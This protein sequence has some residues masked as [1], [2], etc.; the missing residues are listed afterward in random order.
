MLI[1][2]DVF[3]SFGI[4][5]PPI[6]ILFNDVITQHFNIGR[7]PTSAPNYRDLFFALNIHEIK[8]PAKENWLALWQDKISNYYADITYFLVSS[9]E[10]S[11]DLSTF[12]TSILSFSVF[13]MAE[14]GPETTSSSPFK[15][16]SSWI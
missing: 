13:D 2:L 1:L 12:S 6:N 16:E 3:N 15:P 4:A 10:N 7:G 11:F 14:Y 9:V 8:C 5:H